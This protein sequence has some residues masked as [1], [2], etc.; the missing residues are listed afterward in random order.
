MNFGYM[1][2]NAALGSINRRGVFLIIV[3][4]LT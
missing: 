2:E 1:G 3:A 4:V